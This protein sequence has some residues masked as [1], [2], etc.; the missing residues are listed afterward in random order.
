MSGAMPLP[1][2]CA[3]MVWTGTALPLTSY[4]LLCLAIHTDSNL[5]SVPAGVV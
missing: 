2:L 5:E 1:H 4:L 3:F